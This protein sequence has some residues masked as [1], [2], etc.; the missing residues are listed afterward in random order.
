MKNMLSKK[1]ILLYQK[2]VAVVKKVTTV[3]VLVIITLVLSSCGSVAEAFNDARVDVL[4]KEVQ[5]YKGEVN[6]LNDQLNDIYDLF[7]DVS[8]N[9]V[10]A[11]VMINTKASKTQ[12]GLIGPVVGGQGSGVIFFENEV[13]YYILTNNHVV[14]VPS[15]Y[16]RVE[17]EVFDYKMNS[18]PGE[19]LFNSADYDLAVMRIKKNNPLKVLVFSNANPTT[20]DMVIAI[21][22]PEGQVNAITFGKVLDYDIPNCVSC[23]AKRSNVKFECIFHDADINRGNSGG[24]LINAN[25]EIVGINTFGSDDRTVAMAVPISKVNEFLQL[26]NFLL[27]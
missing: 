18:Y 12:F 25:K 9:V 26:N 10:Q 22:Q 6:K 19:L 27:K 7:T 2:W 21:G 13:Y 14:Y 8:L 15:D 5:Y 23:D 20:N 17:Y 3:F 24:M 4:E 16:Q 11:N 1:E